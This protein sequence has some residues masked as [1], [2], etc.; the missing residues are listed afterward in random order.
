MWEE[1]YYKELNEDYEGKGRRILPYAVICKDV[2][3]LAGFIQYLEEKG[4]YC[5]EQIEGQKALLVNM[6]LK[7]WCTFPNPCA[8]SCKD[9]KNYS[10][11]DFKRLYYSTKKYP[12]STEVIEHYRKDFY[13][14]LLEIK[15]KGKPCLTEKQAQHILDSYSDGDLAY[16]MQSH[17]PEELADINTM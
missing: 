8:M 9:S 14:A 17:T 10:V 7:R 6:E 2:D 1:V 4:F 13:K 16:E 15:E 11:E 5:V 3:E 12:Y